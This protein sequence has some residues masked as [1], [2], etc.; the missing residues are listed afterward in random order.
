MVR[1]FGPNGEMISF[2]MLTIDFGHRSDEIDVQVLVS[3]L[4]FLV[5]ESRRLFLLQ[6]GTAIVAMNGGIVVDV[7]SR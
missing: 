3:H 6:A 2:P 1:M 4:S 5:P 7:L